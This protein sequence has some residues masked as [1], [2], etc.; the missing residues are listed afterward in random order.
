MFL[1]DLNDILT[2]G[3]IRG[4]VLAEATYEPS[5]RGNAYGIRRIENQS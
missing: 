5:K 4:G 2:G 1:T 3:D